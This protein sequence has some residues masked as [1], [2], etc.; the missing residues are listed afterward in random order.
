MSPRK[1]LSTEIHVLIIAYHTTGISNRQIA[2]KMKLNHATV[3]YNVKKYRQSGS[4][5]NKKRSA[6]PRVT[7]SVDDRKIVI[8]SKRN[9]RKTAPEITAELN[10]GRSKPVSNKRTAVHYY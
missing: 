9:R 3:D 1:E 6:R 10:V 2:K 4:F 8:T 7:T 5:L